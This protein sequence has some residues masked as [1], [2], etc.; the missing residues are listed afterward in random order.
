M[1]RP[2]ARAPREARPLGLA[3]TLEIADERR[4]ADDTRK[5]LVRMRDGATVETVLI[6]GVTGPKGQLPSPVDADGGRG[7]RRGR[8][9]CPL[10]DDEPVRVTQ[11][12]STQVGCA[13]G[14][15]FCA[16]GVAGLKRHLGADEIV[17][18]VLA[19][20]ARLDPG[21]R[22]SNV[23]YMG[24]GEPLA[25]YDATVRSLR[26]LTHPDGHRPLC[27]THHRLDERPRP[28][29][30]PPRRRLRAARSASRSRSTRPTTR[31]ARA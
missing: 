13:M 21:E 26:L 24:M 17:A 23:V 25:N 27:T 19:G 15:V 4:A 1:T 18:Q 9:A 12:I 3:R 30:R 16:S 20:R 8:R 7:R 29:D 6:P 10:A 14:C 22:L 5:L 11:C 2:A 28:G 31:R